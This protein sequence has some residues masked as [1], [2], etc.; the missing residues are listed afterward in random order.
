MRLSV[1]DE[2]KVNAAIREAEKKT[3]GE[4]FCIHTERVSDYPEVSLGYA[5]GVALLLPLALVAAGVRLWALEEMLAGW[6]LGGAELS[7]EAGALAYALVQSVIFVAMLALMA[8]KPLRLWLTPEPLRR[9]KVHRAALQQFLAKGL[10]KTEARTGVLIFASS[11]DR[12]A[13][14]IAD[15]GIYA[16]VKEDVWADALEALGRGMKRKDPAGGFVDAVA[17]CGAVLAEHFPP[18][19]AN[20]NELPDEIV[21]I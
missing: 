15:E 4:I 19:A 21:Q 8:I 18:T 6:R 20:P 17:L 2:L 13:E 11:A 1:E 9:K 14:V 7:P 5:A 16:K 3:S 12:H 10:H